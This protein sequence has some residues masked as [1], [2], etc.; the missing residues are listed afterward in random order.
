MIR[1][2]RNSHSASPVFR[3]FTPRAAVATSAKPATRRPITKSCQNT[4][5]PRGSQQAVPASARP[6][7]RFTIRAITVAP[8]DEGGDG[9]SALEALSARRR[10]PGP[11]LAEEEQDEWDEDRRD[12]R[13]V[14]DDPDVREHRCLL[15][16]AHVD[17]GVRPPERV[18]R[19]GRGEGLLQLREPLLEDG[20]RGRQPVHQLGLVPLRAPGERGHEE[21]DP[22]APAD[23]PRQVHQA[24]DLVVLLAWHAEVR[25]GV[26]W[27]E[28]ERQR[29]R[30][31]D[32]VH[33]RG[34]S[35]RSTG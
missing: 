3:K 31:V 23:V 4:V 7:K 15:L 12:D 16:D 22:H 18:R 1:P 34:V 9:S 5:E 17:H 10:A 11:V 35:D 24:R 8:P 21:G 13:Q 14:L 20:V 29:C 6:S 32:P 30:L 27:H 25:H 26:D 33:R 2:E 19:T 28:E